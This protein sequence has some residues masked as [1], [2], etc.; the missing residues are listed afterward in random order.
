[1]RALHTAAT[2]MMAQ[3]LNVQVISNNIA[4]L[5]TTGYKRQRAQFQDLLYETL[6]RPGSQTSDQGTHRARGPRDRL[7]REDRLDAAR[8]EPGQPDL[9]REGIRPRHPRRR[10]LPHPPAR[11]THRLHPRRLLRARRARARS[12]PATA[13]SSSP[14]I[15]VPQTAKGVTI[16]AQGQV[17]ASIPGQTQPQVLGQIQL[18]RFVNKAGLESIGDNLFLETRGVGPAHR[19]H[20]RHGRVRQPA[21]GLS[22]RGATSMPSPRSPRSSPPSAP[23]R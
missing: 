4:N 11:R 2:G 8:H 18:A 1:M 3:E 7:G 21:A 17:Q 22:R 5:R 14:A 23:T 9:D 13:T 12:S 20:P 16:S 10:L 15:T 6:R 19:R